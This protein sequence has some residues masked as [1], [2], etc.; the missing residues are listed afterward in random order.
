MES[1][2]IAAI[3]AGENIITRPKL[4]DMVDSLTAFC[5]ER[6]IKVLNR[7]NLYFTIWD[8]GKGRSYEIGGTNGTLA[9]G[10]ETVRTHTRQYNG[11]VP[12]STQLERFA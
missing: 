9:H 1:G 12:R 5:R 2:S 8:V 11:G 3:M 4:E 10:T 6:P 7:P